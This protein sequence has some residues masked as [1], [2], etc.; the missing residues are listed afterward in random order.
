MTGMNSNERSRNALII[1]AG[2]VFP[3]NLGE[4]GYETLLS[5]SE[6][7]AADIQNFF[8]DIVVLYVGQTGSSAE[9]DLLGLA[10]RLR[11]A[12]ATYALPIVVAFD[13]DAYAVRNAALSI[14]VDDYFPAS[15]SEPEMLARLDSLFWRVE[16]SRRSVSISGDQR[17][18]IDSFM[19]MIDS[20]RED[21][22]AGA[23]GTLALVYPA[24]RNGGDLDKS[25]RDRGLAEAQGFLKLNLRRIDAVA[26][27]GPTTLFVYLPR[28]PASIASD[29]LARLRDEFLT[30]RI[31]CD[32][33]IGLAAFPENGTDVEVLIE[34]AEKAAN[35]A[36][37]GTSH[38]RVVAF[39]LKE[40]EPGGARPVAWPLAGDVPTQSAAN[41]PART[42][43]APRVLAMAAG[44]AGQPEAAKVAAA[45]SQER[46]RRARG[47]AMPRRLLLAVSNAARMVQVNSLIR[48][49]GYEAR[50]AFDGQQALDLLRLERP[51]L[52]V[53]D[54][55]LDGINGV[56]TLRRLRSQSGGRLSLPV[57]LLLPPGNDEARAQALDLGAKGVVN[58]PYDPVELLASVRNIGSPT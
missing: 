29:M 38:R 51:D 43:A 7:A 45:A 14:G 1:S 4:L 28:I 13:S 37:S 30:E 36:L 17:L 44:A 35:A 21:V 42:A 40:A 46:E 22:E 11:S 47:A 39:G 49:A 48:Q 8:P 53:L 25:L 15:I 33:A 19:F 54:Y 5:T 26:F 56:E 12:P 32:L 16:A 57:L 6:S 58:T 2:L 18:E 10:R 50:S 3:H 31:D 23:K 52:L 34:K 27:Y 9:T 24:P 20:L 41:D 55:D